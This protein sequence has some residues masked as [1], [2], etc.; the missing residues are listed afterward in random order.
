MQNKKNIII[1]GTGEIGM[2]IASR[3]LSQGHNVSVIEKDKKQL[4]NLANN[5]D[6]KAIHGNGC[7]P[8]NLKEAGAE[9]ADILIALSNIDEVNMVSCQ[10]AYSLFDIKLR[11]ARI[12][13]HD[14][15]EDDCKDL[16]N[17]EDLPVDYII[18]P[19]KQ[20]ADRLLQTL[21][22][23]KALEAVYFAG[24]NHVLF[25]LKLTKEFKY[26]NTTIEKLA[27]KL[28]YSF[29]T[30]L[31]SRDNR[32]IVPTKN[33]H[34]EQ[35]DIVYFLLNT[36]DIE[37]FISSL[38]FIYSKL[39]NILI[40]GGGNTGYAI[41]KDL[42]KQKCNIKVIEKDTHRSSFLAESLVNSTVINA[43]AMSFRNLDEANIA[44]MDIVLNLTDSDEVN[45]LCSM[46]EHQ[47]GVENIYTLI[48]NNLLG[49]L[50]H[51]MH[52]AKVITPRN[53]TASKILRYVRN[54]K[55]YNLYN[56]ENDSAEVMEVKISKTSPLIG[57]SI[58]QFNK[59]TDCKIGAIVNPKGINYDSSSII[60]ADDRIIV[61]VLKDSLKD[62]YNLIEK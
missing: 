50:T 1:I 32:T 33:D 56:I 12:Y 26:F 25:S 15:L 55:I 28:P 13:N 53:I 47:V 8:K 46:Y 7:L 52:Y 20:V 5:F 62:F 60:H 4:D 31:I 38:G 41:A 14:Y 39:K 30:M 57:M 58:E 24:K 36:K 18:S 43:D 61:V 27:G 42:E 49:D 44:N 6:V 19:E 3:L 17:D 51:N 16:F 34:F 45:S 54:S 37:E 10:V 40:I 48:K 29:K 11:M 23:P 2:N 21:S 9:S 22:I 35:N 59:Q